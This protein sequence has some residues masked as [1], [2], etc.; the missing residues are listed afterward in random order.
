MK[1][2]WMEMKGKINGNETKMKG[3]WKEMEGNE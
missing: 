3:K 2:K 1:G